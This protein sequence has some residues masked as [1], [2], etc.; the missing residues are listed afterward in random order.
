MSMAM[1]GAVLAAIQ[2]I[3]GA[4]GANNVYDEYLDYFGNDSAVSA[5]I[6]ASIFVL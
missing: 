5:I 1:V 3:V 6:H 4:T 2:V